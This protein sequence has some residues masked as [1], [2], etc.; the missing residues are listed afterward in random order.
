MVYSVV[1]QLLFGF[2]LDSGV[3]AVA[4]RAENI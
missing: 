2:V 3:Y 4:V 1:E